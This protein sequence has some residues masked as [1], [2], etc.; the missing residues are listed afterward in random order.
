MPFVLTFPWQVILFLAANVQ[1]QQQ[2]T[3]ARRG[4][5][6]P[7]HPFGKECVSV[8]S[9]HANE[10]GK[11]DVRRTLIPP[12]EWDSVCLELFLRGRGGGHWLYVV[13]VVSGDR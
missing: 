1:R 6:N 13:C 3:R 10:K 11:L 2:A 8:G 4:E 5:R 12:S 7:T 9:G